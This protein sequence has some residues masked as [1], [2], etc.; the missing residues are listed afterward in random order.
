[1]SEKNIDYNNL[2]D[3]NILCINMKSFYASI[4]AVERGLDP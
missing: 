3:K 4:E 1:M 2:P